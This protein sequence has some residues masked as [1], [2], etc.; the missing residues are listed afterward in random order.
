[1]PRR[2]RLFWKLTGS[3]LLVV[4][5]AAVAVGG[6]AIG[7]ARSFFYNQTTEWLEGAARSMRQDLLART[8]DLDP[9]VVDGLCDRLGR[10]MGIRMTVIQ[11]D[12]FL[13]GDSVLDP[14]A[15]AEVNLADR[16]E[17]RGALA[18]GRPAT[19]RRFEPSVDAQM[20]YVAVP[21][22]RGGHPVAAVRAGVTVESVKAALEEVTRR[23]ILASL[24]AIAVAT[25][26]A[27][28][29]SRR[30]AGPLQNMA[31]GALRFARGEFD[32]KV[33]VPETEEF[34]HLGRALNRMAKDLSTSLSAIL[35]Q[36]N[37]QAAVLSSMIE[38]VVAV[39]PDGRVLS[40][41]RA[42]A[43]ILGV[44]RA[45]AAG[46]P[47]QEV[48]RNAELERLVAQSLAAEDVVEGSIVLAT[49][50]EQYL[51]V[52]GTTL[53]DAEGAEIGAVVVLHD[54]TDLRRLENM[55]RDFVANV[56]HELKTPI[57]SIQGFVETLHEGALEDPE[58]AEHFLG[59][60]SRHAERL[61]AIIEDLLALSRIEREG[62]TGSIE[63]V[64]TNLRHVLQEAITDAEARA[65]ARQVTVRLDAPDPLW[66]TVNAR[67][68]QHAVLNLLDN[69]VK[70]SPRGAT[71]ELTGETDAEGVR[72]GVT[73]H[74]CGIA[75]EHVGRIF[76]RFYRVDKGRSRQMGGTGLGLAIVKHVAQAHGGR[77]EVTSE[78]GV[79]STF[80]IHLPPP[81]KTG[82]DGDQEGR[83]KPRPG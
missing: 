51:H 56:S 1:M 48:A 8:P 57:T 53:R 27:A 25:G 13:L 69:A 10:P 33:L 4:L 34:A 77:V 29:M 3:Y 75:P 76:E 70:F 16:D 23:I 83:A 82:R 50:E 79:G 28:Y 22:E 9:A 49:P 74:G 32:H 63:R 18:T 17:V 72:V 6:F 30:V 66:A 54:V 62:E 71:V 58:K 46:R 37:E 44:D 73:D 36:R 7:F 64:R 42:A 5:L 67:L 15:M 60:I 26:I 47:L 12:G 35:H 14:E 81:Q 24:A 31:R 65:T 11:L 39:D 21:L 43:A 20:M 19:A 68:L 52:R 40:L 41:N 61:N 78:P 2:R 80:T 38:G 55:R 45:K 59:I